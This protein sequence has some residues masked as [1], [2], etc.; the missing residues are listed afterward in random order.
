MLYLKER[1]SGL[2]WGFSARSWYINRT[3][4]QL[5]EGTPKYN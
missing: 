5:F 4:Q 2:R 1:R 3:V